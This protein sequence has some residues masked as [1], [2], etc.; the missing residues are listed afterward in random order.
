MTDR[1]EYKKK[2]YQEHA[3][4]LRARSR[5]WRSTHREQLKAYN[6]EYYMKRKAA[7][8]KADEDNG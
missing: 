5:E 3:E 4:L 2:Y 1:K 6:H 8:Q 7:K